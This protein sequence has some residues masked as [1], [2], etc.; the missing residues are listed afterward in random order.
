M[1]LTDPNM[2]VKQ[3]DRSEVVDFIIKDLQEA[4]D[5]LPKA[6]EITEEGRVSS[7]CCQAFLSRVALYEGTW[8][9]FRGNVERGKALLDIAVK[10]AER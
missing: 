10:A 3:N 9:K 8:Q 4:T 5:L 2:Y 1:E 6:A 7:E